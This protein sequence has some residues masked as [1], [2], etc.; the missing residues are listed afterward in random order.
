MSK[1]VLSE[2]LD[3]VGINKSILA[4]L[5]DVSRQTIHRMGD[6]VS[7][8][9][10]AAIDKYKQTM[11]HEQSEA[12][13]VPCATDNGSKETCP[14]DVNLGDYDVNSLNVVNHR[15]IALSRIPLVC[16]GVGVDKAII[17]RSFNLS[18]FEYNREVV[19]TQHYCVS[20]GTS[21]MELRA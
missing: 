14:V 11:T 16:A 13:P 19:Q 3:S 4:K 8:E 9:A 10:L 17:A 21:F 1:L 2:L 12:V 15:N 6:N 20:S 18:V 5:M 7:D